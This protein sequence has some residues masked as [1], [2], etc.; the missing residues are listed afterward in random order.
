MMVSMV[1]LSSP[2]S[3]SHR[4]VVNILSLCPAFRSTRQY[5]C[6]LPLQPFY[7]FSPLA[8][9]ITFVFLPLAVGNSLHLLYSSLAIECY[10]Q[11]SG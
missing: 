7:P 6:F 11:L 8:R 3:F 1:A 5:R 9:W 2:D 10:R 4:I